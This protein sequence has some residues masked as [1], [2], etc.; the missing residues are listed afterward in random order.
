MLQLISDNISEDASQL[1]LQIEMLE[2]FAAMF[3]RKAQMLEASPKDLVQA[4]GIM[5]ANAEQMQRLL[6]TLAA[7]NRR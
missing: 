3:E 5:R 4:A 1:G 7:Y 2:T 6:S